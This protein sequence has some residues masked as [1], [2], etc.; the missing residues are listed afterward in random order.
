[1]RLLVAANADL[2]MFPHE[3]EELGLSGV[4]TD[5]GRF[6]EEVRGRGGWAAFLDAR[7]RNSRPLGSHSHWVESTKLNL[8]KNFKTMG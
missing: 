3:D 1:M 8:P 4:K 5:A 6:V 7:A 2:E